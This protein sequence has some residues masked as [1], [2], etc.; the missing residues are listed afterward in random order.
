MKKLLTYSLALITLVSVL[1]S[2]KNDVIYDGYQDIPAGI[3]NVDSLASFD[4]EIEDASIKYDIS[5]NVRYAVQYPYYNVFV[6]HYLVDS[7][8]S[9]ASEE[10]QNLMLFDKKS[11]EPLGDGVGDLFDREIPILKGYQFEM[12]GKHS[13][14]IKQFMRMEE[15]P[16][17]MAFGLKVVKSPEEDQ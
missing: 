9:I 4:F 11:G 2:C 8:Q 1:T 15:L 14:K 3:W 10:L 7:T 16:G 5:Y 17:I 12:P 13:F 6:T